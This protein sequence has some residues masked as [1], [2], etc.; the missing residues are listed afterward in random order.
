MH[1]CLSPFFSNVSLFTLF[2]TLQSIMVTYSQS[3][4]DINAVIESAK[5]WQVPYLG[6]TVANSLSD[7]GSKFINVIDTIGYGRQRPRRG[8][9]TDK[10]CYFLQS[11]FNQND[12][13]FRQEKIYPDFIFQARDAGFKMVAQYNHHMEA[14]VFSCSRSISQ[15]ERQNKS[16]N[17]KKDRI[18]SR[19][20]LSPKRRNKKSQRP[21]IGDLGNDK[22]CRFQML[23]ER[24]VENT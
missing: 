10:N 17:N 19:P 6:F 3:I 22:K 13:Q 8:H 21:M 20:D 23:S 5:T 15:N 9:R 18:V 12:D 14:I 24:K 16:N 1:A 11:A 4:K 7:D 2:V